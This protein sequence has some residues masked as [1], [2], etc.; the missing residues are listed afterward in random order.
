MIKT[1]Y[2]NL[3]FTNEKK[4]HSRCKIAKEKQ[5]VPRID[6]QDKKIM[7]PFSLTYIFILSI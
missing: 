5:S 3:F 6:I 2:C 4:N 7:Y 1:E